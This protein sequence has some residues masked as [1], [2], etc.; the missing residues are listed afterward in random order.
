MHQKFNVTTLGRVKITDANTGEVILDK[1]NAVHPQN[2]ALALARGLAR[3]ADGT[4]FE[5]CFGNGGTFFNTSGQIV[6]RP[7][8]TVGAT[9]L[10]NQ[11]YQVQVDEEEAGTPVTNSVIAAASPDPSITSVVTVT[12]QLTAA[13]PSGQAVADDLTTDPEALFMFDEVGLKTADGLLLSHLIFSP[14]EKTANRAFLI[15]YTLTISVS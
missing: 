1:K 9:D 15:T 5:L 2:M 11:T 10:Y 12:A 8:N 6:Y 14:I 3:D 4:V 13:E 7:P